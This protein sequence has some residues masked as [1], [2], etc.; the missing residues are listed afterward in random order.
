MMRVVVIGLAFWMGGSALAAAEG[1][2]V[3]SPSQSAAVTPAAGLYIATSQPSVQ[4]AAMIPAT[5][6]PAFNTISE[7]LSE[8]RRAVFVRL[9]RRLA[10]ADL[11]RVGEHI[12]DHAKRLFARTQ[13]NYFLPGM[14]L[15]HGPWASIQFAP[16]P[17]IMVHGLRREDEELFLAEHQADHRSLLG[18]W[19][20][21][22]PAAPGRLSIYSDRGRVYAE[23]RL[24]NGQKTLDELADTAS[25]SG[26]RFDVQ[27]G[28]YYILAKS[29][30]L[31]IWDKTT[32]IAVG[33]RIR[34]EHLTLPTA[35]ALGPK[36]PPVITTAP[37]APRPAASEMVA[38]PAQP[39]PTAAAGVAAVNPGST[40]QIT[41][42]QLEPEPIDPKGRPKK[43]KKSRAVSQPSPR[44][45]RAQS[46]RDM[47]PGDQMAAKMSG[48]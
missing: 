16:E 46:S 18:A 43:P 4:P 47:T 41:T 12:K 33:E 42:T 35:V 14:P 38:S 2:P 9:E 23:W 48:R 34:A 19:L 13:V 17:K 37:T 36:L 15:T 10:E 6:L 21:S 3:T 45:S 26:R 32:L 22:P 11:L 25:K 7:D 1:T 8:Q 31:E 44:P 30:E 20:T 40:A 28:G 24:R 29:G 39:E 5:A 27:G